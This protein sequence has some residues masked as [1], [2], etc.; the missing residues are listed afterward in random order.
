[1]ASSHRPLRRDR[2]RIFSQRAPN[3]WRSKSKRGKRRRPSARHHPGLLSPR[4]KNPESHAPHSP[5][6]EAI[7]NLNKYAAGGQSFI[8]RTLICGTRG[9][10]GTAHCAISVVPT[11]AQRTRKNGA[12]P[13]RSRGLR[14]R[15][16]GVKPSLDL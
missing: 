2:G 14:S 3:K 11:L 16:L 9:V 5:K 15:G 8:L 6:T 10:K 7:C 4:T 13:P 1:M 12:P